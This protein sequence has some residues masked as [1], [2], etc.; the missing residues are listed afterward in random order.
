MIKKGDQFWNSD[1][2]EGYEFVSHL[3]IGEILVPGHVKPLGVAKAPLPHEV[4]P[5]WFWPQVKDVATRN[6]LDDK[7]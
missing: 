2:T 7:V 6:I 1:L 4:I 3:N 5:D